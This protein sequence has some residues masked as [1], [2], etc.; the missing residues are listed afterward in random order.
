MAKSPNLKS[1]SASNCCAFFC[2]VA[3]ASFDIS[4]AITVNAGHSS[5]I[6]IAMAPLPVPISA[7]FS[8]CF[9][10]SLGSRLIIPSTN[11]SVSGRGIK[12]DSSTRKERP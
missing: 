1:I 8:A 9:V 4:V 5:F 3:S 7:N 6:E 12:T 10:N 2:A 11:S